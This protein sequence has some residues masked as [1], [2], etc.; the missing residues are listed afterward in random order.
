MGEG[1]EDMSKALNVFGLLLNL[2]GVVL[3]FLCG[4][5]FR[6]AI[7][8]KAVTWTTSSIDLEV[9]KLDDLFSV[10]GWIGLLAIVLGTLLQVW[11]TVE[12]R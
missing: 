12:R 10:L 5:P 4:M 3:L 11:A 8:G 6:I 9:K 1:E 2:A 7:S